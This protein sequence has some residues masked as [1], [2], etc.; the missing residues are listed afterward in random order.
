MG[1]VFFEDGSCKQSCSLCQ[2]AIRWRYTAGRLTDVAHSCPA[3][4]SQGINKT[5]CTSSIQL[6]CRPAKGPAFLVQHERG[7]LLSKVGKPYTGSEKT[8]SLCTHSHFFF[9]NWMSELV[10]L[11]RS[12]DGGSLQGAVVIGRGKWVEGDLLNFAI[13]KNRGVCVCVYRIEMCIELNLLT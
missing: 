1:L 9:F 4:A 10:G 2:D 12:C 3:S 13:N 6:L 7:L 5:N 11:T 8:T